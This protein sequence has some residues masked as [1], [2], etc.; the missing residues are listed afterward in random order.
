MNVVRAGTLSKMTGTYCTYPDLVSS[1]PEYD[2]LK[3][4]FEASQ[5]MSALYFCPALIPRE[6]HFH[7]ETNFFAKIDDQPRISLYREGGLHFVQLSI[8]SKLSCW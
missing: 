8:N 3:C 2:W 1:P 6:S 7:F 5:I 4:N